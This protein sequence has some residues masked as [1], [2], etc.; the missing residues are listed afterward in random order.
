M[1]ICICVG[2]KFGLRVEVGVGA[3][4]V[5]GLGL[6]ELDI[7]LA[8]GAFEAVAHARRALRHLN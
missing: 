8:G 5:V 3:D 4:C 1:E 2:L 7:D 6:E